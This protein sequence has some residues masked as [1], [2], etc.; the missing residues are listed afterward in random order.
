MSE[1]L[2]GKNVDY[3]IRY[4]P[5]LLFPIAREKNRKLL[6]NLSWKDGFDIWNCYEVSW[7]DNHDKPQ[8]RI[9][10]LYVPATSAYIFESKS[11]KLYLYS[12]NDE[13]FESEEQAL[14]V[15]K[16]D[17]E[18]I[19]KAEISLIARSLDYFNDKGFFAASSVCIDSFEIDEIKPSPTSSIIKIQDKKEVEEKLYSHL[20]RSNCLITHQ[21]DWGSVFISYKGAK[22]DRNSLLSYILSFRNHSEFHEHCVER[23]Y[24][25]IMEAASPYELTVYARYTRRGGIDIN[26]IRSSKPVQDLE[27]LNIRL[28]RQ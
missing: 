10:E 21:P 1:L 18:N 17:L 15:I 23:I 22:I 26:P 27:S 12:L 7:L 19:V 24:S 8:I 25:D 14:K 4:N 9:L 13:K 11:L 16:K 28:A 5:D 20:L 6:S 2:L 3:N